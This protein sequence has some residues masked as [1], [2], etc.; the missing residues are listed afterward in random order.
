VEGIELSVQVLTTGFWPSQVSSGCNLPAT[1]ATCTEVFKRHYLKQHSGRRLQWQ[2][3]MG[4]AEL[5][6]RF[7]AS[8]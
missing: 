8:R 7:K 5:K 1:I 4:T 2:A 6:A 3:S